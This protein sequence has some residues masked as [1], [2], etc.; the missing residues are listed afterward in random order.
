[1]F[2]ALFLMPLASMP[3][4]AQESSIDQEITD[5]SIDLEA[6]PPQ[7]VQS[8]LS[9]NTI[10]A[11]ST[12]DPESS[13][14]STK[15]P[16]QPSQ[17][18]IPMMPA[19]DD[20]E[21]AGIDEQKVNQPASIRHSG[22]YYDSESIV[23][24]A[25]LGTSVGPRKVDPK[26]EPGSSFVVVRKGAGANS[27]EAKIVAAQRALKL[28]RY[29]SALE[30]YEQLYKKSPKNQQILMGLAV[31][32]QYSGYTES[33]ITTYEEL[34]KLNPNNTNATI[35]MLGLIKSQ[36][37][38]VAYRK[39]QDMWN[40]NPQNPGLAAQLGLTSASIGNVDDALRYLG[41]AASI[42]PQNAAHFYNMAVISDQAG[43]YRDAVDLYQKALEID[44][45]YGGG[46]SIPRE[47]VYDRLAQLRRL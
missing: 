18:V 5:F 19:Q 17:Q 44:I 22:L 6:L 47:Q 3:S 23:P 15:S 32:Q 25:A 29:T 27:R 45:T 11:T 42:E 37:P 24:S 31:A 20:L 26:Y 34:L 40:K 39:L 4:V 16:S 1:M 9:E 10:P 13:A 35:N 43:A 21:Q 14:D 28:G 46:R 41:V 12:A 8:A 36:Y 7:P 33:A 38:S 2:L 30:I